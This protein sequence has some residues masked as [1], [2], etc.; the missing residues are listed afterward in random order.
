MQLGEAR[1]SKLISDNFRLH[2]VRASAKL[3]LPKLCCAEIYKK[4][5]EQATHTTPI[6]KMPAE[7]FLS[8]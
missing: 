2:E 3:L 1:T 5:A 4:D 8:K 7:D 6:T